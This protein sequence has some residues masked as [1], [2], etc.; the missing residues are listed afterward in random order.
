M[1]KLL[2]I[3]LA[4]Q[5]K[6]KEADALELIRRAGSIEALFH[7]DGMESMLLKDN[8]TQAEAIME[9]C[10]EKDINIITIEDPR[11]PKSLHKLSD[12]PLVLYYRGVWRNLDEGTSVA[13]VGQRKATATGKM[14]AEKFASELAERKINVIS[15]LAAGIDGAAHRGAIK[16]NGFTVGVL[17]TG[18]DVYYPVENAGLMRKMAKEHLVISEFAPGTGGRPQNFPKRNR[19]VAALSRGTLVIEAQVKSGSLITARLA[20]E[21]GRDVFALANF[22][23]GCQTLIAKNQAIPVRDT[24]DIINRFNKLDGKTEQKTEKKPE[25]PLTDEETQILRH[26]ALGKGKEEICNI[27]GLDIVKLTRRINMLEIK[28]YI[29]KTGHSKYEITERV[30]K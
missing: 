9:S 21:L 28:G 3:S 17:G 29:V 11:Y 12:P 25:K 8:L 20:R 24:E 5:M 27:M 23:E 6:F 7:G 10:L 1:N 15:G 4:E 2:Y 19:I 22:S 14:Q 13:I 26:I 16:A 30:A 18:A